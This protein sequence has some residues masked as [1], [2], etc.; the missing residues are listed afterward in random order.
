MACFLT[1]KVGQ[2]LEARRIESKLAAAK[3]RALLGA[4]KVQIKLSPTGAVAFTG[5]KDDDR[6]GLSDVCAFRALKA[7]GSWEFRQALMRAETMAGRK[8]DAAQVAAGVHSHDGGK[9]WGGGH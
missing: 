8:V 9:T 2:S 3:L 1:V 4:G 5:W 7:E 6:E